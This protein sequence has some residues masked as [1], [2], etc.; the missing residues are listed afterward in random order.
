MYQSMDFKGYSLSNEN[1]EI[2]PIGCLNYL[3]TKYEVS[4]YRYIYFVK[5]ML[6]MYIPI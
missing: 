2:V 4:I 1:E 5:K 3:S 6:I